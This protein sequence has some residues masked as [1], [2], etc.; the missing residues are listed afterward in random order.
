MKKPTNRPGCRATAAATDAA[1]PGTLAIS[2]RARHAMRD[3][4]RPPSGPPAP[5]RS[6]ARSHPSCRERRVAWRRARRR[7]SAAARARRRTA[8]RRSGS[9][10]SLQWQTCRFLLR[11]PRR[12][13]PRVVAVP[14][15]SGVRTCPPATTRSMAPSDAVVQIAVAEVVEHQRAGPD[16]A[17]RVGDAL[18]GDVGRRAVD[19]LEHR[20]VLARSGLMLAPGAMPRLPEIA[21]A[22]VGEDVAEQVRGDDHVERLRVGDHARRQRI[23]VVLAVLRPPGSPRARSRRPRPTAP[24]SAAAR[25]TWWRWPAACAAASS[26]AR[27]RSARCARC[28]GA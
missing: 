22:D 13:S 26:P 10:A 15:R 14:P 2:A 27:R 6:R 19:R 1:S 24:S 3:R 9:G 8:S 4:A 20:R 7:P 28:R 18:A 17:D 16:R 5:R 25:S 21:D 23:D 11:D 12:P